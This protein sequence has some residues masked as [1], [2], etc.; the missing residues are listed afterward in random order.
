MLAD[1]AR[2][3]VLPGW[4]GGRVALDKGASM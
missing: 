1:A 4:E 3:V 2:A